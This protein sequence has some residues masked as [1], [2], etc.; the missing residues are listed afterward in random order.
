M[1]WQPKQ[2]ALRALLRA[3]LEQTAPIYVVGGVVRDYLLDQQ[4]PKTD[5]D[6]VVEGRALAIAKRVADRLGWAFYALD[7]VRDVARLVFTV[8]NSAPLVCDVAALRGGSIEA[9]LYARDFTV[10]AMAFALERTGP[11]RLIDFR[12]GQADLAAQL[13]RRV[14]PASLAEDPVRLL[15]AVRFVHQLRFTLEEETLIQIKRMSTTVR[16][17]SPERIRDEL[18]KIL[19]TETPAQA[20][21]D[22]RAYGLLPHVLPEV[23]LLEGVQQSLPHDLDVYH[24]TLQTVA[25][26]ARSRTWLLGGTQPPEE[27]PETATPVGPAPDSSVSTAA[28]AWEVFLPVEES[29]GGGFLG[30][31]GQQVV[32]RKAPLAWQPALAP[33]RPRLRQHFAQFVAS[34]HRRAD[35]LVWHALLHDI[36]KPNARTAETQRDGIVRYRFLG[37]EEAGATL[38]GERLTHLRFSRQEIIL[39]QTVALAHMRPHHL[40]HSF[41]G[42]PIS[43]RACHRFFRDVGGRQF[44]GLAGVD[45]LLLALADFQAI[46]HKRPAYDE[47]DYLAHL[48]E[49]LEFAFTTAAEQPKPLL[50]GH[51]LM[52]KLELP[53]GPQIGAI[54]EEVLEAQMAGEITTPSEALTLA[55]Q[56]LTRGDE[57]DELDSAL[58]TAS[59]WA[60]PDYM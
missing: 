16:L 11:G 22:L 21:D 1:N 14:T 50:D 20:I 59:P 44:G 32:S 34:D 40:H 60:R 24:H 48:Q 43:R 4:Q 42:Q 58:V 18:W 9:D 15:R 5:I 53:P 45:T 30:E 57:P 12:N 3:F 33:L 41:A 8:T 38:I 55:M 37:H 52:S 27:P 10:N 17:T 2:P 51:T 26:A 46:Y 54:L 25:N 13:L 47:G 56:I 7:P 31:G 39:A 6:L 28:E 19:A 36:G 35:W 49:M 23:G 29:W